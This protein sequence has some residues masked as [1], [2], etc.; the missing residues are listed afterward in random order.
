MRVKQKMTAPAVTV[1]PNDTLEKAAAKMN[2]GKFRRL[3]VVE[4]GK[5]VGIVTD[6]D[7]RQHIGQLAKTKVRAVMTENV[8][9]VSPLT[10]LEHAAHLMLQHR[11]GGM[12]VLTEEGT[13]A[14]IV[15]TSDLLGAFLNFVGADGDDSSRI[16]VS[17]DGGASR[18]ANAADIAVQQ[19][20]QV[21][22]LGTYRVAGEEN[23]VFYL[24]VRTDD[25]DGIVSALE[26]RGFNVLAVHP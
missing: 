13:V 2:A 21:L 26:D 11:I 18:M 19:A 4:H 15:T 9:T 23:P 14:G 8:V 7:L 10:T 3:P 17:L 24:R 20:G 5:L 22:G 12:P 25:I 16:D 6:R 1:A